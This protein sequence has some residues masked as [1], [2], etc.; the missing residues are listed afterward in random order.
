MTDFDKSTRQGLIF[1]S[2]DFEF[3]KC[4]SLSSSCL[5]E[6]KSTRSGS[7]PFPGLRDSLAVALGV[8]WLRKASFPFPPA[9]LVEVSANT[10]A[11]IPGTAASLLPTL[12]VGVVAESW[13][14]HCSDICLHGGFL[15]C[16]KGGRATV[17][18]RR[19]KSE[20]EI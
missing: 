9:G 20:L 11:V 13:C 5:K 8:Q 7:S 4:E 19:V 17:K 16:L 2:I 15:S 14:S 6:K 18:G 10:H 12:D 3:E 1:F